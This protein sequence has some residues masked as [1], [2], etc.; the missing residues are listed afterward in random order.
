MQFAEHLPGYPALSAP[1][2]F[3]SRPFAPTPRERVKKSPADPPPSLLVVP[4]SAV[5][6]QTLGLEREGREDLSSHAEIGLREMRALNHFREAECQTPK[7]RGRQRRCLF[8]HRRVGR[9]LLSAAF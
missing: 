5:A 3:G 6:H 8:V 7:V 9:T 2:G 1:C 4:E